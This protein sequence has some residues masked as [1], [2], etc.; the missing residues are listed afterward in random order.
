[1]RGAP[2][3]R[4][5]TKNWKVRRM[6]SRSK[7]R[8]VVVL[9]VLA[10][11]AAV[12]SRPALAQ[13]SG[14]DH[15]GMAQGASLSG[16]EI[17]A[18]L[19]HGGAQGAAVFLA[20]LAAFVPLVVLP[21]LR[22]TNVEAGKAAEAR[23]GLTGR[24]VRRFSKVASVAVLAIVLTGSYAALLHLPDGQALLNTPYGR[25][26]IMK[27]GM[28]VFMFPI[29]AINLMDRGEGPFGRMVGAELFLSFAVFV[30]T[31][32]LTTLPPP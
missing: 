24:V 25:A 17:S 30:A 19:A 29:A 3:A 23:A 18:A 21:A 7:A 31:G 22:D 16:L 26:L 14:Q 9:V 15:G 6:V 12:L 4:R 20:G 10:L 1:M 2:S 11:A 13:G 28:V 8:V 32:F 5:R 27:L